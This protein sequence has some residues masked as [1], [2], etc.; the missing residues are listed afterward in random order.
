M[1]KFLSILLAMALLL[2]A[3]AF[4][5]T[6]TAYAED[7][8]P[9]V[10]DTVEGFT[11]RESRDFPLVGAT[12]VLFE[13]ERTGAQLIYIA[14]NDTNRV[15][16]LSFF[17]RAVDNTGLPHVFEHSTLDGSEKYPSKALFFNL[18]YQTYNSYMNAFTYPLFTSYPVGSLSE[19]QLLKYADY[20]TDSCLHP[21]IM[22]DESIF[23][24]EAWRYR[25]ASVEDELSIE[26]TVYSE[27]LGAMDLESSARN[28]MMRTAFPGSLIGNESGGEPEFIPDMTWEALQDFH[29]TYYHPSN[30]IA[31]LYG[32]FE[33]YTAF[34][35]LLDEAFAPYEKREFSFEDPDYTPLAG[36][37]EESF[38]FPVEAG[39]NTEN[40][41]AVYYTFVCPGVK[42]D[43][44]AEMILNT[45]T[46]LLADDAS[47]LMQ[48][49]KKALPSGSFSTY[50]ETEG[51]E[52]AVIF[53]AGNVN[54]E[55]APVFRETVDAAL[56]EV[57]EKG[58][59]QELVD[60]VMSSLSLSM[61]LTGEGE[62]VGVDLISQIAYSH[63][64][65]GNPFDY[66]DYV[67]ALEK[68]DD[69]NQQGLYRDAVSGQLLGS[70]VTALVSTYPQPGLR[71]ELD[72]ALAE[73]LAG[74]KAAMSEEELHALVEA[75]NAEDEEDD[76][77]EYVSA[78]Q[79]VTT[80]SLPE[81]MREYTITDETG[82]DN[83]RR[84]TAEA[85]VDGVSQVVL[86][87]DA[88]GL[89][90]EDIHWFALYTALL[91]EMDTARHS[92]EELAA[93]TGR[94]FYNGE[95]R[96]SLLKNY[97]TDEYRPNLRAGWIAGDE[98]LEEGYE[99]LYELLYET[100]FDDSET[101]LGLIRQNKA[102]LKSDINSA[103]YNPMLYRAFA[104][105]SPLYAYYY[106][107]NFLD[108]YAFLEEAER[109]IEESPETVAAKL[110]EI[111]SF[112]H[113][114]TNA[115]AACAGSEE[116]LAVN[117]PLADAFLEKLDANPVE[118]QE[119]R[120][121][122]CAASEAL[123]VDSSVQYN[124]VVSSFEQAGLEDYSA[125]QDAV[126]A[127]ITD[128]YLYPMLRDQYGVY[129]VFHGFVED[130]GPYII[131]YRD[132][133]VAESF[134]VLDGLADYVQELDMDQETLD[135]YILSAYNAYAKPEGE[136]SGAVSA[137]LSRLTE[138]PEDLK[139]Q[140]MRELK[141]LTPETLQNYAAAYA[142]LLSNGVR[143]TA[144]GAGAIAANS[145]LYDV[146]LNPF[147][148]VDTSQVG[149]S[150]LP[151]DH[152]HYEAVR[153]V[154]ENM[155][156]APKTED[157]FGADDEA[158]TGE[159][160]AVLYA[161]I[162]GDAADQEGAVET[163]ASYGILP[164]DVSADTVLTGAAAEEI[165]SAFSEAAELPYEASGAEDAPLSRGEL[166]EIIMAYVSPLM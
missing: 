123:V 166:A 156:M 57:A 127:L 152:E 35:K 15:F 135:G 8:L 131:T 69:W 38:A 146:T 137:I 12:A 17:T 115:V 99:L 158:L 13:H 33:D 21:S 122:P 143:F 70:A 159:L 10:G 60:S 42:A 82:E 75:S 153:F 72:A 31:Y 94:Y 110:E 48:G 6:G 128:S 95:I 52:D 5:G 96:L 160:A 164:G 23:R 106:Y 67:D 71:E 124:G 65:S 58:F 90:Q 138:E 155:L 55:D 130:G 54:A 162:G 47:P 1:K 101:L 53:Y 7:A 36:D 93:L 109:T 88:S 11:V 64:A 89:P 4:S 165:L 129:S 74:I 148:S 134:A 73:K 142:A 79:V 125:E 97:G 68:L 161:L 136:L 77:S 40:R 20:Y 34:L 141:A 56:A 157:A 16:D 24:E 27:M 102:A 98:D 133:N 30:C 107:F 86:L 76:A 147:G 37:V 49:L 105:T 81:E 92:R 151:E 111:Q 22:T 113:N 163:L 50:I 126:A 84:I 41:S 144:G 154:F 112:F 26:G 116:S 14:N 150:D 46:D 121:E 91:G 9:A 140:H 45:L 62:D 44:Q 83:V 39:A 61:K 87:L 149:F 19:D 104:N 59:S 80:A 108:Y 100:S 145:D 132:P 139:L 78:L 25:L 120:F 29:N 51:P 85:G 18:I 103:P 43:P 32:Q 118:T 117:A 28:H 3:A 66:M 114:R 2:S 119:Y 63:A